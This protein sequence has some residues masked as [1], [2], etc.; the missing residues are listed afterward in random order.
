MDADT[1]AYA[2]MLISKETANWA[3]WSMIAAIIAAL[4]SLITAFVTAV[5]ALVAFRTMNTWKQQEEVKEKKL[6]KAALVEYR[7]VLVEMPIVMSPGLTNRV[8]L[9]NKLNNSANKIYLPLV[10]LEEDLIN[11]ELGKRINK[12]LLQHYDFLSCKETRD[13]L[14]TELS[15]LLAMKIIDLKS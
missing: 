7:N 13:N 10:V 4:A 6:L 2:S 12:F 3:F 15:N 14:A 9:T 5:A 11:G 8:E 1:I